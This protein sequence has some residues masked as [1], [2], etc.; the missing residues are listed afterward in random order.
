[1]DQVTSITKCNGNTVAQID[2]TTQQTG[3]TVS[4]SWTNNNTN[5]GLAASGTGN[6]ASFTATNTSTG[7]SCADEVATIT[8][9]PTFTN[10]STSCPGAPM[11]F[12]ITVHPTPT[13]TIAAVAPELCPGGIAQVTYTNICGASPFAIDIQENGTTT[14]QTATGV[15]S[16]GTIT[17]NPQPTTLGQHQY[18]LIK[19]TDN[20]GCTNPT[21]P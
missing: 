1:M 14:T 16:G 7:A 6:I 8:V 9:T 11:T 20:N 17:I 21:T 18:N 4:Y 5:I 13:A 15:V 2:F 19:I 3:G 10:G 12:T